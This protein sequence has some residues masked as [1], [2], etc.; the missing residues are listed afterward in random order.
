MKKEQKIKIIKKRQ[1]TANAVF[2]LISEVGKAFVMEK[3]AI[4]RETAF[5]GLQSFDCRTKQSSPWPGMVRVRRL[6]RLFFKA[7]CRVRWPKDK[8][9]RVALA[10]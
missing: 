10:K 2:R 8:C 4:I 5:R 6:M 7:V 3:S 9:L 1:G